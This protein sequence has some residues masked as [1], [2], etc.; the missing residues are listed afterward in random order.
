MEQFLDVEVQMARLGLRLENDPRLTLSD[1]VEIVQLAEQHGFESVWV[2][3]SGGRDALTLLATLAQTT[4]HIKFGT[5]ILPIYSRTPMT[6][7]MSAGS[8]VPP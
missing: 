6:I 8:E 2:P 5:G 3:E 4:R 7:A 1:L